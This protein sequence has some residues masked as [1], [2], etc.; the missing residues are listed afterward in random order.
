MADAPGEKSGGPSVP[1][2]FRSFGSDESDGQLERT[3]SRSLPHRI[4]DAFGSPNVFADVAPKQPSIAC[5]LPQ[6]SNLMKMGVVRLAKM[7]LSSSMMPLAPVS[8]DRPASPACFG[9]QKSF[10]DASSP[11]TMSTGP[12]SSLFPS[13]GTPSHAGAPDAAK[14]AANGATAPVPKR[15]S[16]T[17]SLA[18]AA[19]KKQAWRPRRSVKP[20]LP[21]PPKH[22]TWFTGNNKRYP[23][24]LEYLKD[25]ECRRKSIAKSHNAK[26]LD[27]AEA[28]C[29]QKSMLKDTRSLIPKLEPDEARK[30]LAAVISGSEFSIPPTQQSLEEEG[31]PFVPSADLKHRFFFSY[32][33]PIVSTSNTGF[34]RCTNR[35]TL[36]RHYMKIFKKQPPERRYWEN[37]SLEL[38]VLLEAAKLAEAGGQSRNVGQLID[39]VQTENEVHA[40]V[41]ASEEGTS[42]LV[43]VRDRKG[44]LPL[45][46]VRDV[47]KGVADAFR[48]LHEELLVAHCGLKPGEVMV[49]NQGA[50][51]LEDFGS[52]RCLSAE[53]RLAPSFSRV[54][55]RT[56]EPNSASSLISKDL[57]SLG[58]LLH[59]LLYGHVPS[60]P[61]PASHL[62]SGAPPLLA[63]LLSGS[64]TSE[65]VINHSW[66]NDLCR[67]G[68]ED[69]QFSV[70]NPD[71]WMKSTRNDADT[72]LAALFSDHPLDQ[73]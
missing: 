46:W 50:V 49:T 4:S 9:A 72:F 17:S 69:V 13:A 56:V 68:E 24:F 8:D 38:A 33:V 55:R 10:D 6:H 65:S 14:P 60:Y 40:I 25:T 63:C 66:I 42:L 52:I 41:S 15:A 43:R 67:S 27:V 48:T 32:W 53:S 44:F 51:F 18:P 7:P 11:R 58:A 23:E 47:V 57:T 39:V 35:T 19:G 29:R 59:L 22:H 1:I 12:F 3:V 31:I 30:R 73:A 61:V 37:F 26:A 28:S 36:E 71:E 54:R 70:A 34:Y 45:S 20:S 16:D 2:T 5:S 64:L 21:P 62:P